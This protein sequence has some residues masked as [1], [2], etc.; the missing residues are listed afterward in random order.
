MTHNKLNNK[1]N[2]IFNDRRWYLIVSFLFTIILII[3]YLVAY[4]NTPVGM[5]FDGFILNSVDNFT[6]L[7][8]MQNAVDGWSFINNYSPLA[9]DGGY[10]F[11]FYILSGKIALLLHI[12]FI[13]MFHISRIAASMFLLW[14]LYKFIA[15]FQLSDKLKRLMFLVGI[16]GSS[17]ESFLLLVNSLKSD[18][19][20][21]FFIFMGG[22]RIPELLPSTTMLYYPHI[23]L[24]F[25]LQLQVWRLVNNYEQSMIKTS[26]QIGFYLLLMALIHP[27]TPV[28]TGLGCTMYLIYLLYKSGSL[29]L[30]NLYPI[31]FFGL[32]PLPYLLYSYRAFQT[33]PTLILW[34]TN[35]VPPQFFFEN[36][37]LTTYAVG[38]PF[39][40]LFLIFDKWSWAGK[41]KILAWWI[42][43]SVISS[44]LP[45]YFAKRLLEGVGAPVLLLVVWWL[46]E[47]YPNKNIAYTLLVLM[48]INTLY[49]AF[50]P[51]III[52]NN[53]FSY[54]YV[55]QREAYD[56][57]TKN[58]DRN[59]LVFTDNFNGNI[60]PGMTGIKVV[61]GHKDESPN[62]KESLK[63]WDDLTA[64]NIGLY[65]EI[66]QM[67]V[68][69][70]FYEDRF[71]GYKHI[72]FSKF[73]F[74][75]IYVN[76]DITIYK[77]E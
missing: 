39:I 77:V 23:I 21:F 73:F 54:Q 51:L 57:M 18:K 53:F 25:A 49:L 7:S 14:S 47:K 29:K 36:F 63:K 59:S 20:N 34:K 1:E 66:K 43:F 28:F 50:E 19:S 41:R 9:R 60:I 68:D 56:W 58:I 31:S 35:M 17:N 27:F 62:Y 3:P 64:N 8:K 46:I 4:I 38:L 72:D 11:M 37:I 5:V 15:I 69:Y 13:V 30:N 75:S 32:I 52:D 33:L 16:L 67:G 12:P 24:I 61:V 26:L 40:F 70:I 74:Q 42:T 6:Y 71:N 65:P 48:S 76:K 55:E 10:H 44:M 45:I 22:A 2:T